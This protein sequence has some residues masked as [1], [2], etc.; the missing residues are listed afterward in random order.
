LRVEGLGLGVEG[1]GF[2]LLRAAH[3]RLGR[4]H[5]RAELVGVEVLVFCD[6]LRGGGD[7]F[8]RANGAVDPVS[9]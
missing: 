5:H 2:Y 6:C 4:A 8:E 9:G 3:H 7:G 1:L